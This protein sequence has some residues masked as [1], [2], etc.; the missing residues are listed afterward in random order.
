MNPLREKIAQFLKQQGVFTKKAVNPRAVK[1]TGKSIGELLA[2]HRGKVGLTGGLAAG[3]GTMAGLAELGGDERKARREA[4]ELN[5]L[6]EAYPELL[7][8]TPTTPYT[9]PTQ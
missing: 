3:G 1:N 4:A 7:Y 8:A 5:Q 2:R 6:L 9:P